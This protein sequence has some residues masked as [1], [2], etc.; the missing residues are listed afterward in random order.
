MSYGVSANSCVVLSR[1]D[2]RGASDDVLESTK[3]QV[4]HLHKQG[5]TSSEIAETIGIATSTVCKWTQD[6]RGKMWE[7][8]IDFRPQPR[9]RKLGEGVKM[10]EEQQLIFTIT[11][12]GKSPCQLGYD[13]SYWT[14]DIMIDFIKNSFGVTY[15]K[16]G[17]KYLCKRLGLSYQVPKNL[18]YRACEE[19]RRKW[20]KRHKK[21]LKLAELSMAEVLYFDACSVHAQG[22][23]P[24]TWGK[25]GETPV[26]T[27]EFNKD[28]VN[29]LST[30]S[31]SGKLLYKQVIGNLNSS[32]F[33]GFLEHVLKSN[34]TGNIYMILDNAAPHKSA[35]TKRFL[36]K[37]KR[38][39][40]FFTSILP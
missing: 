10:S 34:P 5:Y 37:N 25:K 16:T 12:S 35:Q 19:K 30:I 40:L 27:G 18:D 39:R 6:F 33:I 22:T 14:A 21:V 11:I 23:R 29:I 8:E 36:K 15:S 26:V 24:A 2:L 20:L 17:V 32:K 13:E 1:L 4:F 28:K 31:K 7:S 9:G 3:R 38:L